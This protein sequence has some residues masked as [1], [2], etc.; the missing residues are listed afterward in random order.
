[1]ENLNNIDDQNEKPHPKPTDDPGAEIET[2]T[3]DSQKESL[4]DDPGIPQGNTK[5]E[6]VM[7]SKLKL[8]EISKKRGNSEESAHPEI[9]TVTPDSENEN[10]SDDQES[11]A[12]DLSDRKD[13]Y[14]E[15]ND[16]T[17]EN[18]DLSQPKNEEDGSGIET[19]TP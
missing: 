6:S 10:P 11:A 2:V 1:M 7:D 9:E 12:E 13:K 17:S 18:P 16:G 15:D 3:P 5:D 8:D 4:P 14:E 19:V